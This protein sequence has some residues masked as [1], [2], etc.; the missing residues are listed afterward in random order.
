VR[1][2]VE[3]KRGWFWVAIGLFLVVMV[4]RAGTRGMWDA[5]LLVIGGLIIVAS[6]FISSSESH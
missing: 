1:K 3:K 2:E 6:G 4:L 5:G